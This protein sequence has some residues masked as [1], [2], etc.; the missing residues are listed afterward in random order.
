MSEIIHIFSAFWTSPA[1]ALD[2]GIVTII[3]M[4]AFVGMV[5]ISES[6]DPSD[7]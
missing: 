4:C 2:G 3:A 5:A 7:F 1:G 6:D